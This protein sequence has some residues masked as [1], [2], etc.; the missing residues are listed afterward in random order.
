MS[1]SITSKK[2]IEIEEEV[3]SEE[4]FPDISR[5]I[6]PFNVVFNIFNPPDIYDGKEVIP[7]EEK[8]LEFRKILI[9]EFITQD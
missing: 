5:L 1:L 8:D 7:F 4:E 3:S 6:I 9:H 2:R